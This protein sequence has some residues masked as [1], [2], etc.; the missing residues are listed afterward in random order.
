MLELKK[1]KKVKYVLSVRLRGD[2][3]KLAHASLLRFQHLKNLLYILI[4]KYFNLTSKYLDLKQRDK[5]ANGKN[6]ELIKQLI[7]L[8]S[9]L[10]NIVNDIQNIYE[11]NGSDFF[12]AA[13]KQVDK[14]YK[15]YFIL[16][17]KYKKGKIENK[18]GIPRPKKLD[19]VIN[20]NYILCHRQFK[21]IDDNNTYLIKSTKDKN[22][23]FNIKFSKLKYINLNN[24]KT[25]GIR[26]SLTDIYLD[27]YYEVDLSEF[28]NI[29]GNYKLGIDL[30]INN[31]ISA[32]SNNPELKS[33]II[34]GNEI[35]FFNQWANKYLAKLQSK[36][37]LETDKDKKKEL[38]YMRRKLFAYRNRRIK[39]IF[40]QITNKIIQICKQYGINEIIIGDLPSAKQNVNLGDKN[41][42]NFYS[43]PFSI[44]I[45]QLKY[46]GEKY[47]IKIT[48]VKE[49]YTSAKSA[50]TDEIYEKHIYRKYGR[51]S[52]FDPKI[53]KIWNADIN[54]AFNIIRRVYKN[55]FKNFS[56]KLKLVKLANPIKFNIVILTQ[57]DILFII[58][59]LKA[60]GNL[61]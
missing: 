10:A 7:Q 17:E 55:A 1:K 18:P 44:L 14:E 49:Y 15:S 9:S 25:F 48:I 47:G 3:K 27:I 11:Y 36:I 40:H 59:K 61:L 33:F 32:I 31:L 29:S 41:N 22:L 56:D 13:N 35:K 16:L 50:I 38:T 43:I 39:S 54:G 26:M 4:N 52:Y 12:Q 58:S 21:L 28:D 60:T 19:K 34:S 5:I 46:K 30:G 53:N 8:D 45:D 57:S 37:D 51:G 42:Q 2:K 23:H 24:I 20:I 6:E